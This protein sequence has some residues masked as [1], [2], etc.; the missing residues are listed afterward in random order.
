MARFGNAAQRWADRHHFKFFG[1]DLKRKA[2]S[3]TSRD[4]KP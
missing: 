4:R 1:S 2:Y 3:L